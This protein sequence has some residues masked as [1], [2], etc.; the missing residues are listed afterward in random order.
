MIPNR[1]R[2][3]ESCSSPGAS[4]RW[5][6]SLEGPL[7][8]AEALHG[9]W[10]S[11]NLQTTGLSIKMFTATCAAKPYSTRKRIFVPFSVKSAPKMIEKSKDHAEPER[12]A[13]D[14]ARIERL[15]VE[16]RGG[17]LAAL[18]Q[19]LDACRDYLIGLAKQTISQ[20]L[21][22]KIAPSDLVQETSL[23][24]HRDFANFCGDRQ[25]ELLAWLR[26][27]LLNNAASAG[28]RY[29]SA[30]KRELSREVPLDV[31]IGEIG[32]PADAA[33]S[34]RSLL[35]AIEEQ[36]KVELAIARLP[37]D[38][39]NVILMR[40]RDHCTFSEIGVEMQRSADA[41]RQLWVRAVVGL[42]KELRK[43]DDQT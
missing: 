14:G 25:E 32:E 8:F 42:Q 15:I 19:L 3:M 43:A 9:F 20:P 11:K 2:D 12:I 26:R 29:Q 6:Y 4:C 40:N 24:A 38:Q 1:Q 27:I 41:A 16:A 18:G 13:G 23:D 5:V 30:K 34:P 39:R 21:Q 17:S 31:C 36:D 37:A 22:A 7:E 33:L 10:Q 35:A 28:R